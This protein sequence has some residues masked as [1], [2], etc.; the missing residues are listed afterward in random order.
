MK[1]KMTT[2]PAKTLAQ[3]KVVLLAEVKKFLSEHIEELEELDFKVDNSS[4]IG[5]ELLDDYVFE[6]MY[7]KHIPVAYDDLIEW[8]KQDPILMGPPIPP[9]FHTQEDGILSILK[10][11]INNY[12]KAYVLERL[13]DLVGLVKAERCVR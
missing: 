2:M 12:L 1:S 13:P 4:R 3:T 9:S 7:Y 5:G 6:M 11:N 10:T 8:T